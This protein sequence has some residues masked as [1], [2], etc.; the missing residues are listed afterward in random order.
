[1]QNAES[2]PADVAVGTIIADRYRV[3]ARLGRGGMGSVYRAHHIG[4]DRKVAL[5]VL[6][7]HLTEDPMVSKRFDREALAAS[8]LDHVN[9][10]QMLDA[11]TTSDGVKYLVMQLLEGR[12]L[13]DV[14]KGPVPHPRVVELTLQ[15]LA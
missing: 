4:L 1:M 6:H 14:Y 15:I 12:E 9:C 10:V 7:S 5:K 3:E 13:K 11:G 2:G 8:K